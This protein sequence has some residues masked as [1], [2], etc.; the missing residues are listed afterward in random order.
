MRSM[1]GVIAWFAIAHSL[2]SM[3]AADDETQPAEAEKRAADARETVRRI[4]EGYQLFLGDDR[5]AL[6]IEREPVLRWPN[7]T[8]D[9]SEGATFLWTLDGRPE[10]MADVWIRGGVPTHAFHSF[11][12]S[13]LLAVHNGRTIWHPETSGIE[14]TEFAD[15][16]RPDDSPAKRLAQMKGLARRFTCRITGR[17]DGEEL[18]LLPRPLYRYQTKASDLLD[19]A[20][21]AFVQGTDPEVM[22]LLEAVQRA[23][24]SAWEFALTRDSGVGLEADLDGKRIW[25]VPSSAGAPGE[26]WF[27]GIIAKAK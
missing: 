11:S 2:L 25:K 5:A 1:L 27:Q 26:V 23:N 16:P 8:R 24:R 15:G 7:Q 18:R 13:K 9:T 22:L 19:G 4:A 3:L 17:R 12:R 10:A 21:F 6:S 14:F 20:L